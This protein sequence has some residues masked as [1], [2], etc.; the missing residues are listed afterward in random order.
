MNNKQE[1]DV[2]LEEGAKKARKVSSVVLGKVRS[3]LGFK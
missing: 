3:K 2:I 1:L